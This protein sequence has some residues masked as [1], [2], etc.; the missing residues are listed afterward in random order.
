MVAGFS[1][2]L[3]K[4]HYALFEVVNTVILTTCTCISNSHRPLPYISL[5][6]YMFIAL[7]SV[8]VSSR[9]RGDRMLS[10]TCHVG[11]IGFEVY[12]LRLGTRG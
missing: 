2:I 6:S 5:H 1:L 11:R 3:K 9:G 12:G 10:S 8:Y 4:K 7:W